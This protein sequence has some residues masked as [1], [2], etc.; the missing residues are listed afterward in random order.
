MLLLAFL[1]EMS[2]K[3]RK[4]GLF[5]VALVDQQ[6]EHIQ[7][8]TTLKVGKMHGSLN[9]DVWNK[10][11]GF[12]EF[13]SVHNVVVIT[14]QVFLDLI[15][16]AYFSIAKLALIIF[17]ECHHA[18]G[19]KHPYRV[20]MD[21]IM[22]VSEAERPRILGLT[23]SLINDKTPPCQLELSKYGARPS[24]YV[25]TSSDYNPED[26]CG[27]QVLQLLEEWRKFCSSTQEF[28][29]NFDIDPRKPIQEALN[30]TLAVLRQVGPWAAWKVSQMWEKELHKLTK[31]TFLQP[32]TVDFLIMGET[33]MTTVRKLLEPKMKPIKTYEALKPYL[34]NKV[35]RLIDILSLFNPERQAQKEN[36]DPLSGIIFVDQRYVAYT[37]NVLLKHIC[38]W[39][40]TF[41]FIQS[42][43]VI[44]FSGGSFA[45]DDSQGLHK[46]QA[47]V[48]R[49]F[50]QGELNLIVATNVLE[51]GVDVRHCNLVIKFNRPIDYRSYI[52]VCCCCS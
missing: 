2:S 1:V 43:F 5:S 12:D 17:D 21:R 8:H 34:P 27:G 29:A 47:E 31:Q 32:K 37:L 25:V 11:S 16:H 49:R 13:M 7:C 45:S 44:G 48:I 14:A 4:N 23:A 42:D 22:R 36:D 10:Q 3:S 33:C 24:E 20:I 51:E 19:V 28:D 39:E 38:R 26:G 40:P 15:D 6:A 9:S 35:T 52:Q 41:K 50:R 46:R 30:R 18:L